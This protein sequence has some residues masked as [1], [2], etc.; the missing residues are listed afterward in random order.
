[1]FTSIL[2]GQY[3]S[4]HR[5]LFITSLQEW[6]PFSP[7]HIERA[8]GDTMQ[9]IEATCPRCLATAKTTQHRPFP[10]LYTEPAVSVTTS[11][12]A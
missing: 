12:R 2:T 10:S 8:F 11:I 5:L 6:L 3:C 4:V 1:M 9:V 7:M